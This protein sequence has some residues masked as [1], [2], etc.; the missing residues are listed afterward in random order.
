MGAG[1]P[2]AE[3]TAWAGMRRRE[4]TGLK[5]TLSTLFFLEC[6]TVIYNKKY[7]FGHCPVSGDELRAF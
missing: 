6:D 5:R 7:I 3:Q 1:V 4:T 2:H